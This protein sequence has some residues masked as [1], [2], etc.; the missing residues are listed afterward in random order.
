VDL[1]LSYDTD[2]RLVCRLTDGTVAA[3]A[4]ASNL[5]GAAQDLLAALESARDHAFGECIWHEQGGDY[6]WM[7]CRQGERVEVAVMWC[8]GVITGWQH[9][10]RAE[11]DLAGLLASAHGALSP[12][13]PT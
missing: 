4:T 8:A 7:F 12:V 11:G 2:G 5:P 3:T 13:S 6:R 1:A 10:F 9:V